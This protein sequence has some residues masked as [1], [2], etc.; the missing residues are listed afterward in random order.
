M[1]FTKEEKLIPALYAHNKTKCK[2]TEIDKC[3]LIV[4]L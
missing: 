2:V 4:A 3:F 1:L